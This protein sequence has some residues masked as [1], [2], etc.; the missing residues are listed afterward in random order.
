[1]SAPS[2]RWPTG[3][4]HDFAVRLWKGHRLPAMDSSLIR[5][6]NERALGEEFGWVESS[7]QAGSAGRSP[8]AR[9]SALTDG[10]NRIVL[11]ARF[12]PLAPG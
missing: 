3:G 12:V 9:W 7:P 2:W 6:P 4:Q 8:Q 1:M 10:L 5:L 11:E